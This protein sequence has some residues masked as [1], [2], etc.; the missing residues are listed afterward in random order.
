MDVLFDLSGGVA[1][2]VIGA[3]TRAHATSD[4][5]GEVDLLGVRFRPGG[6]TP[7][8]TVEGQALIDDAVAADQVL[9]SNHV[10]VGDLLH[11]LAETPIA[12]RPSLALRTLEEAYRRAA[13]PD[14]AVTRA[15]ER[16][17]AS[18]GTATVDELA[19]SAGTSV[20]TLERRYRTAFG[21]TPKFTLRV[22]RF[23][24]AMDGLL[25]P[26]A[27]V[28]GVAYTTGYAD[29]SHMTREFTTLAGLP[30]RAWLAER[31]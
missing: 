15:A 12:Q 25:K 14:S 7:F 30:P 23:R 31:L 18:G 1:P 8:L 22:E 11:R 19:E 2:L 26:G 4:S 21:M 17:R 16:A 29:Q 5:G 3:M 6:L 13:R 10:R 24:R 28:S 20:R 9:A 27:S